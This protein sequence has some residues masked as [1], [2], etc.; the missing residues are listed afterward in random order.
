MRG[1]TAFAAIVSAIIVA[2]PGAAAGDGTTVSIGYAFSQYL[3]EG[4]GNAP[5]GAYLSIASAQS[6]LGLE[7]DLTYHRDSAGSVVLNTL[8]VTAGPRFPV[9]SGDSQLYLHVLGGLRYDDAS[10]GGSNTSWGG[11]AGLG[12]DVPMGSSLRLRLGGDFQMFFDEGYNL[13]TLRLVVGLT[14]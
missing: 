13:K 12:A 5:L 1:R 4:G 2:A 6:E 3:E 9:G 14:F 8:T 11:M 7:G 10:G